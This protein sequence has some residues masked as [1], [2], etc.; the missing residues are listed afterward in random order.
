MSLRTTI[1]SIRCI[2]AR[3]QALLLLRATIK[4]CQYMLSGMWV[5][6]G[7]LGAHA[8]HKLWNTD[9]VKRLSFD[10][11]HLIF[12]LNWH[13]SA[14]ACRIFICTLNGRIVAWAH[15]I[16]IIVGVEELGRFAAVERLIRRNEIWLIRCWNDLETAT[17]ES[18]CLEYRL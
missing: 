14:R 11:W 4:I 7:F 1:V 9:L 6:V 17:V 15:S 18:F 10:V 8:L 12:D 13:E 2:L 16:A 5:Y 3:Y